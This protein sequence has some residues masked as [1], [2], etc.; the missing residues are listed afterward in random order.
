MASLAL[1]AALFSSA[2]MA[3]DRM[4][5]PPPR[6]EF[7]SPS[8]SFVFVVSSPDDWKSWT[9]TGELSRVDGGNRRSLWARPLPQKYRPRFVVVGNGGEVLLLDEW[10]NLKSAS[11]VMLLDA[12]NRV[13]ALHPFDDVRK[14]LDVPTAQIVRAARYGFWISAPP[15]LDP[16]GETVLVDAAGNTVVINLRD[17]AL[18]LLK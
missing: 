2:A 7:S 1:A 4:R 5:L 15:R 11:A 8:G 16:S 18:S 6:E 3:D 14:I 17:G 9:S 13:V 12:G 10:L